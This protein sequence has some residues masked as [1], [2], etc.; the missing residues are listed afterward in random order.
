MAEISSGVQRVQEALDQSGLSLEV[1]ELPQSSRTAQEA[2]DAVGCQLGQIVKSLVFR[3]SDSETPYLVLVSGPNR[4][5]LERVSQLVGEPI[6]MGDA[7]FVREVTGFS[8]GGVA[9]VGMPEPIQ[10]L[11][12]RD[13]LQYD[14]IWA[15]AGTPRSV[16]SLSPGDLRQLTAGQVATI[17]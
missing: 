4:A 6:Q 9:P 13:L 15:A 16:F 17:R 14:T 11:I 5:D 12:D 3:G 1:V 8:I 2:A 10:T 7:D